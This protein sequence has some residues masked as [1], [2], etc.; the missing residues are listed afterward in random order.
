MKREQFFPTDSLSNRY[1]RTDDLTC[2]DLSLTIRDC[3]VGFFGADK[4][5]KPVL[6]FDDEPRGLILNLTNWDTLA[7]QFG[8]D[9]DDWV[10]HSITLYV[11]TGDY[12][13]T[14]W[15]GIRLR[16]I[17]ASPEDPDEQLPF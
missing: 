12:R 6:Y 2:G 17:D 1:F 13:G 4:A 5:Q 9:S 8:E 14:K 3:V 16:R 11:A 7:T 10:G 15:Q